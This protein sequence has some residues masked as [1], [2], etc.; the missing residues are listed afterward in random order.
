MFLEI[1]F[2]MAFQ[3]NLHYNIVQHT[4][5]KYQKAY[6]IVFWLSVLQHIQFCQRTYKKAM[7]FK[8]SNHAGSLIMLFIAFLSL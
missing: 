8:K 2:L 6:D 5:E 7:A 4:F 1:I 3:K